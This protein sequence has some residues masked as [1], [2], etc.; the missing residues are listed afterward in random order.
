MTLCARPGFFYEIQWWKQL[1]NELEWN[2]IEDTE[3]IEIGGVDFST[4][5]E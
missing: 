1:E 3:S 2:I 4:D 5:V